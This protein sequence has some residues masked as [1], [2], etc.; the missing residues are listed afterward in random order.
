MAIIKLTFDKPINVSTQVG[1]KIYAVT[2]GSTSVNANNLAGVV[3]SIPS[4]LEI[5]IDDTTGSV[6]VSPTDFIMFQKDNRF[7][8]SDLNG[9]YAEVRLDS[10]SP[11]KIELY[12]IG[13]EVSVSSK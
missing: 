1:D 8:T 6:I 5:R 10:N 11:G 3:Y 2:S 9:Y 13:S 4:D 12:S 7:N